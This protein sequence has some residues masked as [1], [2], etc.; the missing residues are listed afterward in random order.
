DLLAQLHQGFL[1]DLPA[2]IDKIESVVMSSHDE[3]GYEE[4][5]RLVHSLKGSAGTYHFFEISKIA[6]SMEDVMMTLMQKKLFS[7][8]STL[9]ILL[10]FI[11][12]LRATTES[13]KHSKSET[14]NLDERLSS[15]RSQVFGETFNIIV[16]EPSKLYA[17]LIEHSL[18][19]LPVNFTYSQDGLHALENLLINKYDL[20]ITS[21]ESP[22]LNGDALVAALRLVHN[23]N[24]GINVV[25]I[26]SR[27]QDKIA[28]KHDFDAILDRKAVK[29]GALHNIVKKM[30]SAL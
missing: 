11:D 6:H 28:N 7:S 10:K 25:L 29:D 18:E 13:L 14:H 20:L 27:A 19:K 22:R 21:M 1:E 15:L 8:S 4:L 5:F 17:S 16:V 2:R 12:I 30:I 23:F 24:K 3:D 26:T 9:A